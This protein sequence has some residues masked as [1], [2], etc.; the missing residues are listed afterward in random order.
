MPP[1]RFRELI[2]AWGLNNAE[3]AQ[4]LGI[5]DR[6]VRRYLSGQHGIPMPTAMLLEWAFAH[7][8]SL[9]KINQFYHRQMQRGARGAS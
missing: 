5:T 4:L 1:A 8:I 6:Q 2:E 7:D 3:L 9:E